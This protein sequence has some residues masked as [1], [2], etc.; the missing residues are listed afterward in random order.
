M[1]TILVKM[2]GAQFG[3]VNHLALLQVS[4]PTRS[5]CREESRLITHLTQSTY[6]NQAT[7]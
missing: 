6:E 4:Y 5:G 7:N 1:V 2:R 3:F